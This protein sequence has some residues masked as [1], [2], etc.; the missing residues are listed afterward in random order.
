MWVD[1]ARP[2][3]RA[4]SHLG[5]AGRLGG[6]DLPVLVVEVRDEHGGLAGRRPEDARLVVARVRAADHRSCSRGGW[7]RRW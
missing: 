5:R 7:G 2:R 6:V 4:R 1:F 3:V